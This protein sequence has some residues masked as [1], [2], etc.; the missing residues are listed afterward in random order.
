MNGISVTGMAQTP[1]QELTKNILYAIR[2]AS[3]TQ[4][5]VADELSIGLRT[6]QRRLTD[7]LFTISDIE[8]IARLT[9]TSI[10]DL[11]PSEPVKA[12]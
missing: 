1:T 7:G 11:L 5:A 10:F 2:V 8:V 9:D 6:L 4:A 3:V 12:A